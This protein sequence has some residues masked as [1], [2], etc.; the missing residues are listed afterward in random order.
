MKCEEFTMPNSLHSLWQDI[1]EVSISNYIL[2]NDPHLYKSG[3]GAHTSSYLMST[4]ASSQW[5]KHE[6]GHSCSTAVKKAGS[7]TSTP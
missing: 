1:H 5:A 3:S 7:Y 2:F 4:R 6:A